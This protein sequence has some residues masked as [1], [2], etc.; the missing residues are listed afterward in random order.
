MNKEKY[1]PDVLSEFD[2]LDKNLVDLID[3][4][5]E[6]D[7]KHLATLNDVICQ[8]GFTGKIT[9]Y[10]SYDDASNCFQLSVESSIGCW[11]TMLECEFEQWDNPTF[12]NST[13]T[14]KE[15]IADFANVESKFS[16]KV[17]SDAFINLELG[18][19]ELIQSRVVNDVKH[20]KNLGEVVFRGFTWNNEE[21][22]DFWNSIHNF[23]EKKDYTSANTEYLLSIKKNSKTPVSPEP[24]IDK[25]VEFTI[26]D[27]VLRF[28]G[29]EV[30][31]G[32]IVSFSS[33]NLKTEISV[34]KQEVLKIERDGYMGNMPIYLSKSCWCN[35]HKASNFVNHGP[36]DLPL[37]IETRVISTGPLA[38]TLYASESLI[39]TNY[40]LTP[41][42]AFPT[43]KKEKS[44]LD[45]Q[46]NPVTLYKPKTKLS[47]KPI[48]L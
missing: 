16:P 1:H 32:D 21:G 4:R 19:W 48:K 6:W 18:L 10:H 20:V 38:G 46:Q 24:V 2:K 12:Q 35:I 41:G 29:H 25:I 47:L 36:K 5:I 33:Y 13:T 15:T 40:P 7:V 23:L 28:D 31:V 3:A 42:Q 22:G 30:R 39:S 11:F 34:V 14:K 37:P 43:V 26:K 44:I 45:Y 27:G 9:K 8:A 17:C